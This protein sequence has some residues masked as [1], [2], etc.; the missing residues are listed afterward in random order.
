ME[1]LTISCDLPFGQN[2]WCGA[3]DADKLTM[4]SD[5]RDT[6]FGTNWGVL[7]KELRLLARAV[8]VVDASDTVTYAQVV[9]EVTDHPNYD[10]ALSAAKAAAGA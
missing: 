2:R 9:P 7:I 3:A 8:F 1:V 4:L 10:D 6:N 5:H